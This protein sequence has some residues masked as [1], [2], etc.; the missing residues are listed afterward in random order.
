MDGN[1]YTYMC[2]N[3][4]L[5]AESFRDASK[6]WRLLYMEDTD[7]GVKTCE[8]NDSDDEGQMKVAGP[9]RSECKKHLLG[10]KLSK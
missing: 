3:L 5:Q 7:K 1:K 4:V 9:T 6:A 8:I 2:T 10:G